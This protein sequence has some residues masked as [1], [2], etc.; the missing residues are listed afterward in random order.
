M[1][2]VFDKAENAAILKRIDSLTP[3][4]QALWGKM[5]VQQMLLHCQKPIE[6]SFGEGN[7][8]RNLLGILIGGWVKRKLLKPGPLDRNGPT[9]PGFATTGLSPDFKKEQQALR[10]MV[11]RYAQGPSSIANETHPFFGKMTMEEWDSL[12]W[13]H[14]DHHL[15]QF[16]A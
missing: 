2:S 12:Q 9:A 16:G 10:G 8:K 3:D 14:L 11:E 4:T 13:K 6:V 1:E 15:R 5:N 7:T